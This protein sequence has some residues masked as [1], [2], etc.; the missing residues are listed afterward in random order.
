M[1]KGLAALLVCAGMCFLL[2]CT[3]AEAAQWKE[4]ARDADGCPQYYDAKSLSRKG[5]IVKV[6]TK[7]SLEGHSECRNALNVPG[8]PE[9]HKAREMESLYELDCVKKKFRMLSMKVYA[10]ARMLMLDE[11]V[12][13]PSWEAIVPETVIES[14]STT[15]CK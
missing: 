8:Q 3:A 4:F 5:S 7:I 10:A 11:K 15:V 9:A 6:W 13:K 2:A 12:P 1:R 14:L